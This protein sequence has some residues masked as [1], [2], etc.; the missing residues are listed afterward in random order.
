MLNCNAI[1]EAQLR[2]LILQKPIK[3]R[4]VQKKS[5]KWIQRVADSQIFKWLGYKNFQKISCRSTSTLFRSN[6]YGDLVDKCRPGDRDLLTGI[7]RIEQEQLSQQIK[8]SLI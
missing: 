2:G 8:T 6:H 4:N 1:T 3:C 5:L 7:V